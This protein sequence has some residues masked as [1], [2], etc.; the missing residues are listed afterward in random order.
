MIELLREQMNTVL[1]FGDGPAFARNEDVDACFVD[2]CGSCNG[3]GSTW[4]RKALACGRMLQSIRRLMFRELKPDQATFF[5]TD[6]SESMMHGL[7]CGTGL[8]AARERTASNTH[9]STQ[10]L[11]LAMLFISMYMNASLDYLL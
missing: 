8:R 7:A 1:G 5:N 4:R 10:C 6:N 3:A 11:V 2:N 9:N